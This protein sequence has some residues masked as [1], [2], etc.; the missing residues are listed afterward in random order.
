MAE[1]KMWIAG[2]WCASSDGATSE[3]LNPA[4][5]EVLATVPKATVEDVNRCVDAS[6]A[7][8]ESRD[9][10]SMDP[11]QRGRILNKMAAVTYAKAKEL[12]AL[13]S[14]N[15]GKTFREALSEIRYGA[16]TFEYF[17]GLTDK[18]EGSTIPV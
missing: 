5:G 6:R 13:E 8:F 7:A 17:A 16:W 10:K 9:W 3:A 12:A 14:A 15:N 1:E 18:I 4:N 2:E 11:A